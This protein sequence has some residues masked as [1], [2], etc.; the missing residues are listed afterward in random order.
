MLYELVCEVRIGRLLMKS[1]SDITIKSTFKQITDTAT[2]IIPRN[3]KLKDKY[4]ADYIKRGDAVEIKLGYNDELH[5]EFLGYVREVGSDIPLVIECE[6]E[7]FQLKRKP[8]TKSWSKVTLQELVQVIAPGYKYDL[9]DPK[10]NLGKFTITGATPAKVLHELQS[11]YGLYAYFRDKVLH[12]GFAYQSQN[13][14]THIYHFQK[15]VK[16]NGLKFRNKEEFKLKVKAISNLSNGKKETVELGDDEGELRTLNF[17][18]LLKEDLKKHAQAELSKFKYD[19][20]RG[21]LTGFGLPRTRHGDVVRLD[22]GNYPEREGKY[23]I[24]GVTI[25]FG[26]NGYERNNELGPR[27]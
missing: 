9:V 4:V 26:M 23:S 18:G 8:I 19:G 17:I 3:D 22:D 2:I 12:V 6:D 13:Y 24:D 14:Q 15:N 20:Y 21:D 1:V 5:T 10:M 7:M 25:R 16:S 11:Q 27:A